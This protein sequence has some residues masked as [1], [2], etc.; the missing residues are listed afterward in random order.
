MWGALGGGEGGGDA[1][2]D[3]VTL[4]AELVQLLDVHRLL[5]VLTLLVQPVLQS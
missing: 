5:L 3:G 4:L 2:H 1:Y